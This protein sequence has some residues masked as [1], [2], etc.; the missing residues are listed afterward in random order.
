MAPL[1]HLLTQV[2]IEDQTGV[3]T[4]NML[5]YMYSDTLPTKFNAA[6]LLHAAEKY[7]LLQLLSLIHI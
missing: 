7:Q 6:D 2:R 4:E 5:H 1:A 3:V